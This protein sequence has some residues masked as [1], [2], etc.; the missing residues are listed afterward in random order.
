MTDLQL[1]TMFQHRTADTV[2][3]YLSMN[4]FDL[5][6]L[7]GELNSVNTVELSESLSSKQRKRKVEALY[8]NCLFPLTH[9]LFIKRDTMFKY[10]LLAVLMNPFYLNQFC[11]IST[12]FSPEEKKNNHWIHHFTKL[13]SILYL[14]DKEK[15]YDNE[16]YDNII[17]IL[18]NRG[19]PSNEIYLEIFSEMDDILKKLCRLCSQ[20][21]AM[22]QNELFIDDDFY[23]IPALLPVSFA[24][25]AE[26]LFKVVMEGHIDIES[27]LSEKKKT[28]S[29]EDIIIM[30]DC[31][32]NCPE[33]I[34]SF[35]LSNKK[36]SELLEGRLN[37]R[38]KGKTIHIPNSESHMFY[39]LKND[40]KKWTSKIKQQ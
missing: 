14:I 4:N 26:E 29:E 31:F 17:N 7:I 8:K 11:I 24:I 34:S 13:F 10:D 16:L 28:A 27:Y 5:L 39:D 19:L 12:T 23:G 21:Y 18:K 30:K 36:F 35:I 15:I 25:S 6:C 20:E 37:N 9:F 38:L 3:E 40:L 33:S 2:Q 32:E 1:K 22:P